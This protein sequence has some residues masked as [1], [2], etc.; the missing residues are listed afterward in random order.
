MNLGTALGEVV[1]LQ[2]RLGFGHVECVAVYEAA[3]VG[4][5]LVGVAVGIKA[6]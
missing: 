6:Q 5:W 3:T 1:D 2:F 4:K